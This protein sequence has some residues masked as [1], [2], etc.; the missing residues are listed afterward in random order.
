MTQAD[1][2]S[3]VDVV[4]TG[5]VAIRPEHVGPTTKSQTHWLLT[6]RNWTE[7]LPINVYVIKHERGL[8]LFDTGQDRAS[9]T[10]PHYFPGGPL[11][12]VYSRL[13]RFEIGEGDTLTSQ[14]AGAGFDIA[15]VTTVL[16]SHLHQDHIGGLRE[17]GHAQILVTDEEFADLSRPRPA[18][19]GLLRKHIDLPGLNWKP[20]AFAPLNGTDLA[21]FTSGFDVFG[22][23][24]LVALPTPG[25]TPGSCSLL[26]R[27]P[28]HPPLLLV[29]DLTYDIERMEH[30]DVPGSGDQPEMHR[31]S[32]LVVGLRTR[33]PDLVVLAAHDPSA[34]GRLRASLETVTSAG[35]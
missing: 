2:I 11:G 5:A 6:S 33:M 16:I 31:S 1:P 15:D 13:A 32:E 28:G 12:V 30:G 7:P 3:R 14:L 29:G 26:V 10:D 24:T 19:R 20:F 4:S 23:A 17:L 18:M 22:D 25:H 8:V 35:S 34:A 21:P 27:R 9:V